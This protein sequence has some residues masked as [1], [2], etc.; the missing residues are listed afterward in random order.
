MTIDINREAV[1]I[2]AWS[3]GKLGKYEFLTREEILPSDQSR[4]LE[5]SKF[6]YSP[7]GKAFENW[8]KTIE[9]EGIKQIE[10]LKALKPEENQELVSIEGF[11]PRKIRN[12]EIKNEIDEI[13]DWEEK[14]NRKDLIY[15]A[16]KY[17]YEMTRS[18]CES[19]HNGKININEAEMDQ[20]NLLENMVKF[21][22]K[23]RP[24]SKEDHDKEKEILM[25]V[26]M[27]FMKF[28]N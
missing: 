15:K 1:K 9:D 27:L 11:F 17:K 13:K 7:L 24:K 6:I 26:H 25:K 16:G 5:Q 20:R 3:S 4:K 8:I 23:S 18:F 14:I 21:N 10:V 19:I 12:T 28:E 22:N 2:S